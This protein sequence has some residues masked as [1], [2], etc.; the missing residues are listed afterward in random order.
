M[1]SVPVLGRSTVLGTHET[2]DVEKWKGC[3]QISNSG[4]TSWEC[5]LG[6]NWIV[7]STSNQAIPLFGEFISGCSRFS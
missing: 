4:E 5:T 6:Q 7:V 3:I 1:E 2:Y